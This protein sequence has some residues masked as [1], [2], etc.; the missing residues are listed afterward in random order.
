VGEAGRAAPDL[1]RDAS[2]S[3]GETFLE[4]RHCTCEGPGEERFFFEGSKDLSSEN[5]L[6]ESAF[7]HYN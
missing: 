2:G 3:G 1:R 5:P 6:R 4:E 7:A